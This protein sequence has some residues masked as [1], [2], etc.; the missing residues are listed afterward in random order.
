MST[1][2]APSSELYHYGV[3][4]MKWGVRKATGHTKKEIRA[5]NKKAFEL[6][7][8]GTVS[9]RAHRYAS[10]RLQRLEKKMDKVSSKGKDTTK[11][12]D[13]LDFAK[14]VERNTHAQKNLS[15]SLMSLHRQT[16]MS[17][18]GSK[19]VSDIKTDKHGDVNERINSGKDFVS[20]AALT[21]VSIAAANQIGASHVLVI[22]PSTKG[23]AGSRRYRQEVRDVK[24]AYRRNR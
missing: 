16:L 11:L 4:G 21:A 15:L 22:R 24:K 5:D 12:Q 9:A 1:F 10:K 2:Y 19:Y 20:S 18:Y 14:T 17:K 13:K 23:E 6:G 3:I 8:E 7:K